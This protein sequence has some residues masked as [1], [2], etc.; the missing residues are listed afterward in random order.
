MTTTS[1]DHFDY[2]PP[3]RGGGGGFVL[4]PPRKV[5]MRTGRSRRRSQKTEES[6][7]WYGK[8]RDYANCRWACVGGASVGVAW[9]H[10]GDSW[11]SPEVCLHQ[12]Q[13]TSV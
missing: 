13:S 5:V 4:S 6:V 7:S 8:P 11:E 2:C 9:F 12:S 1:W 3:P 10:P